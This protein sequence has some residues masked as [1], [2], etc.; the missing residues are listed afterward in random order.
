MHYT[1]SASLT[2][3]GGG[4]V[5]FESVDDFTHARA[6]KMGTGEVVKGW[7]L[8]MIGMC[9]GTKAVLTIPPTVG[10]DSPE[11]RPARP[12]GV[13]VGAT[14]RYEIEIIAVLLLDKEGVPF[15][16]CFFTMIDTDLSGDLDPVELA[17]HF[18]RINKP[19]PPHVMV[20][21][22][23]GDGRISYDEFNGPKWP[24]KDPRVP[25]PPEQDAARK[26][27]L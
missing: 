19:V 8:A 26:E 14:L 15:R 20:E 24:R 12:A 5:A 16:P 1:A 4:W 27:E 11:G 25:D 13:P 9:E 18:K 3:E 22:T 2:P 17:V 10:F 7:G 6:I 23:D 21:D